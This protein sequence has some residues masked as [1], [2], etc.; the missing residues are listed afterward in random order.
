MC[1]HILM[2]RDYILAVMSDPCTL[3]HDFSLGFFVFLS[4][5]L[6]NFVDSDFL[7]TGFRF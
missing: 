2:G 6:I 1:A 4:H 3:K 5:T 7:T